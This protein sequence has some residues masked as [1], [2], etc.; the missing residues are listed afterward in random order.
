M[1]FFCAFDYP[2]QVDVIFRLIV[3]YETL[4]KVAQ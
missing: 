3:P 4:P 1:Y 2:L